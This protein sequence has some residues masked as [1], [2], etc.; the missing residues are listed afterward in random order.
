MPREKAAIFAGMSLTGWQTLVLAVA[1]GVGAPFLAMALWSRVGRF[2]VRWLL[3]AGLI[4]TSQLAAVSLVAVLVNDNF[5]FYTSWRE[6]VGLEQH[7]VSSP[8]TQPG[9]DDSALRPRTVRAMRTGH[10]AVLSVEIPGPVSGVGPRPALVYLPPQYGAPGYVRRRFPVVELIAGSGGHPDTWL[11]HLDITTVLDAGLRAGTTTPM[12]VVMPTVTVDPPRDTECVNVVNGPRV[13]TYLTTDVRTA[14][15]HDFRAATDPGSWALLGYST[16]GYCASNLALRHPRDFAA[17][18]SLSGYDQPYRD[19][20]T[21]EL[22]G[23]D[24]NTRNA[25]SPIWRVQHLPA[26]NLRLLL[27][28]TRDD[29]STN[30]DAQAMARA[31]RPPLQTAVLTLRHGGHNFSVWRA[32]EPTAFAW[33]SRALTPALAPMP[34]VDGTTPAR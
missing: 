5:G 20:T 6:V 27:M 1:L 30:H 31:T 21:G 3:R 24:P 2:R 23:H 34:A 7:T 14:V 9:A 19:A 33:L 8:P 4:L 12:I 28:T 25:N 29:P 13:D 18:V 26:P 32:E 16:G 10:G 22:F 15:A 11:S 17:A